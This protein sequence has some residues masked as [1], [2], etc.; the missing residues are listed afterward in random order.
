MRVTT[1]V[2]CHLTPVK[3]A[4]IKMSVTNA[5]ENVEKREPLVHC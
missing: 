2:S 3:L 4:I 5:D 1:T